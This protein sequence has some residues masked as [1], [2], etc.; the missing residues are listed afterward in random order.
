MLE[1]NSLCKNEFLIFF[2]KFP[3]FSLSGKMNIQIP[4]F[5]CAVAT[6]LFP[7]SQ[8]STQLQPQ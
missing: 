5:P 7:E 8:S 4:G 3:V 1:V 2:D 6:L